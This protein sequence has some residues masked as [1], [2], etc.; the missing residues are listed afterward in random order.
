MNIITLTTDFGTADWFVGSMKGVILGINPQA[1]IVDITHEVPSRDIRAG[2]FA[3]L[4]SYRCFPRH[5]VHLAVVDPGV[6]SK[7]A[8]IAVRTA[9]YFFVG[10]DNGVLS[11]AL[12]QE[13]V[14]EVRRLDNDTYFYHA[15]SVIRKPVSNTFHGHDIFAPVAARLTQNVPFDSLGEKLNDYVQFDWPQPRLGG[16]VGD[17]LRGE[18]IYIDRFG[19]AITNLDE[20]MVRQVGRT[21][22]PPVKQDARAAKTGGTPVL[23]FKGHPLCELKRFYQEAPVGQP[24]GIIGSSGFLEIAVNNGNA[25]QELGL[26]IGDVVEVR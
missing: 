6:G 5:T 22:V 18:I 8:A 16:A 13:K 7:R 25:A 24:L 9:D 12:A 1:S 26:K 2:A 11:F 15:P 23:L 17:V 19:N 3:L 21:G 10:P 20:A 4:A 14:V